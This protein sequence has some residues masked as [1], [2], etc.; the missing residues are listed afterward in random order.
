MDLYPAI[1]LRAG[2][3]VRLLRG[4]YDAETRYDDDPASRADQF[5]ADG[6]THLHVVDLDAARTGEPAN[7]E[8]IASIAAVATAAGVAL[9]VGGGVRSVDAADALFEL[10]VARVVIGTAAVEEPALVRRVAERC[11]TAGRGAVAVGLD[12][13]G[14]RVATH[15]WE[16]TSGRVAVELMT[17]MADEG[18]E[19]LVVTQISQDGTMAGPDLAG[20]ARAV[21]ATELDVIASGGVGDGGDL[22][23]LLEVA[24][25][26]LRGVIVG[27]AL[28]EGALTVGEALG[29]S[30][31]STST[32]DGW[33]RG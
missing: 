32:T 33:S 29:S 21:E 24:D 31:A 16:R 5:V 6:A 7:R 9:Q 14:D 28:Y 4:D 26:G 13:R 27:R 19:A 12:L 11:R 2:R 20:L 22:R 10:G 15:G 8:A 1:D 17:A 18:A 25:G 3:C 30:P 23:A